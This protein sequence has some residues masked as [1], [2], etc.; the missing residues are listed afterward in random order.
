MDTTGYRLFLDHPHGST[1]RVQGRLASLVEL[2]R[3][4][5]AVLE[6]LLLDDNRWLLWVKLDPVFERSH[7][8][9]HGRRLWFVLLEDGRS[10]IAECSSNQNVAPEHAF[11]A[12]C[13]DTLAALGWQRPDGWWTTNWHYQATIDELPDLSELLSATARQAFG[14]TSFDLVEVNFQ[15][16]TIEDGPASK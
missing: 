6:R 3:G 2:E 7:P 9:Q 13:E 1:G 10:V 5:P 12:D 8:G 4:H 11:D 15:V 16:R 14:L